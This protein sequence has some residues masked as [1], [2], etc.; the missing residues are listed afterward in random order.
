MTTHLRMLHVCERQFAGLPGDDPQRRTC[1]T[2]ETVVHNLDAMSPDARDGLMA[3]A[4]AEKTTVCVSLSLA[5]GE[6]QACRTGAPVAVPGTALD[7]SFVPLAG[8]AMPQQLMPQPPRPGDRATSWRTVP[9]DLES[10]TA[11]ITAIAP[12]FTLVGVDAHSWRHVDPQSGLAVDVVAYAVDRQTTVGVRIAP[13]FAQDGANTPLVIYGGIA[14]LVFV[15][16]WLILVLALWIAGLPSSIVLLAP[17]GVILMLAVI[18]T[19]FATVTT[20]GERAKQRAMTRWSAAWEQR[21][22]PALAARLADPH[23]YR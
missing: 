10:V 18:I 11:E 20:L 15:P 7:A 9:A 3:R 17:S 5:P 4:A 22:W 14:T 1:D 2:C 21:F 12:G 8:I 13:A 19:G 16:V 23:A 6:A